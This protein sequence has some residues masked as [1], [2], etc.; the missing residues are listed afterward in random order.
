MSGIGNEAR[1]E[2]VIHGAPEAPPARAG[3][4]NTAETR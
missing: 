3:A 1:R 4:V 2:G